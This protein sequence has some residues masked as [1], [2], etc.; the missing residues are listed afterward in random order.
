M[1]E[2]A[3][4]TSVE[5]SQRWKKHEFLDGLYRFYLEKI[6]SFHAF[7]LPLIGGVVAYVLAHPSRAA[8]LGLVVPLIV[9]AGAAQIFAAGI[10]EAKELNDALRVSAGTVGLLATHAY[11]LVRAVRAFFYLHLLMTVAL[12]LAM[13]LLLI[14]GEVPGLP[15]TAPS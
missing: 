9:S 8:A 11:M 6:I 2:G 4:E 3:S 15:A 5:V 13:G 12:L 7:Y 10:R 1:G 14:Y